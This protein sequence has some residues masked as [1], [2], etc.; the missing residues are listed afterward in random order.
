M[1]EPVPRMRHRPIV[2]LL[3]LAW[4]V[5]AAAQSGDVVAELEPIVV[6]DDGSHV[7]WVG[8]PVEAD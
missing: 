1:P 5:P 3:L 2:L 6:S 8:S 4:V 7:T